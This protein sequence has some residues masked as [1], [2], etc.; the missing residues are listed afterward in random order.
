MINK[1]KR[2]LQEMHGAGGGEGDHLAAAS[3]GRG[4]R[5]LDGTVYSS[6]R[7]GTLLAAATP[8]GFPECR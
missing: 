1:N 3:L 2:K 8:G 5:R 6:K 7:S 4:R